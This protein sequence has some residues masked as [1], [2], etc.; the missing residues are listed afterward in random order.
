MRC[1][2]GLPIAI[3]LTAAVAQTAV[4]ADPSP[5]VF[6]SEYHV[7]NWQVEDGLPQNSVNAIAQT[8]DGFLWMGTLNGLV[9]FDGSRFDSI[10]LYD[11]PEFRS[12]PYVWSLEVSPDGVLWIGAQRGLFRLE[13]GRF[14]RLD[15]PGLPHGGHVGSLYHDRAG[16][17]WIG[18]NQGVLFCHTGGT[19]RR[20]DQRD[21]LPGEAITTI[22]KDSSGVLWL[23][24]TGG[25][26]RFDRVSVQSCERQAGAPSA[27]VYALVP[28]P[29]AGVWVAT[30][31]EGA[32]HLSDAGIDR[33][34][35]MSSPQKQI[36]TLY[37][38][39][40]GTLWIGLAY[41]GL[42]VMRAGERRRG[43]VLDPLLD[44]EH[45]HCIFEDRDGNLWIG[46]EG[47]GLFC[48]RLKPLRAV[49]VAD[50]LPSD[51]VSTVFESRAGSVWVGTEYGLA[52]MEAGGRIVVHRNGDRFED[53]YICALGESSGGDL[54]IGTSS[55]LWKL[56]ARGFHRVAPFA[57]VVWSICT[58]S[59]SD[60]WVGTSSGLY[61]L[62]DGTL[63][64]ESGDPVLASAEISQIQADAAG[65]VWVGTRVDGIF[66]IDGRSCTRFTEKNGL[67]DRAIAA[68]MVGSD[69]TTWAA[70][71]SGLASY[72]RGSWRSLRAPF[73]SAEFTAILEDGED[74]WL[75]S[76][77]GILKVSKRQ[78]EEQMNGRD[79]VIV[80]AVFGR[81][82]GM[83]SSECNGGRYPSAIAT[84]QGL[85]LFS[86]IKGLV[87]LDLRRLHGRPSPPTPYVVDAS[88]DG[89]RISTGLAFTAQAGAR[90][91]DFAYSCIDF[92][93]SESPQF[94]CMLE[95]F[96]EAW[97][98]AGSD[99]L[100][101]YTNLKPGRYRFRVRAC[102]RDGIWSHD[103][104]EV[105]FRLLP[106][107]RQTWY[108]IALCA[109]AGGTAVWLLYLVRLRQIK[110]RFG[111]VFAER[112][113]ISRELHDTLAQDLTSV[114]LKLAAIGKQPGGEP[115]AT[116]EILTLARGLI[117][118]GL[119]EVRRSVA[120]LRLLALEGHDLPHALLE[121]VRKGVAGTSVNARVD[122]IG[123]ARPLPYRTELNL[124]RV[125]QEAV[126]NAVKH[127]RGS[128]VVVEVEYRPASI[129]MRV[130]DH[131][132]GMA[133]S[134][135]PPRD[136]G[137]YGLVGM[138]ERVS[139]LGGTMEVRSREGEGTEIAIEAPAERR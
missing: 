75:G 105:E 16:A 131:G 118:D 99:R 70:T 7:Q 14:S 87:I 9:R 120:D 130:R 112:Q 72:R 126:A 2:P 134:E 77:K 68:L 114:S 125:A 67:A 1:M 49:T 89:H 124:F 85:L 122:V 76:A 19:V 93:S 109:G 102:S 94:V 55:G 113:R 52:Q 95:G 63:R 22:C 88:V 45:I 66:R 4:V 29:T 46:T 60:T 25:L 54:L 129:A 20:Y 41:N 86:T 123:A 104:A 8:P 132:E 139:L 15:L 56:A 21:G 38:S 24:T 13:K 32:F 101:Q 3:A 98:S 65:A 62:R 111:A 6:A 110:A 58:D 96:E 61:R 121:M 53:N 69:G 59:K 71:R 28:H 23:G 73:A 64:K 50:G 10:G 119:R 51:F 30:G 100:A 90:S 92:A 82:E 27:T 31:S 78:I 47:A 39:R 40:E 35:L 18:T 128:E 37:R 36:H 117:G 83:I 106:L 136:G 11:F 103:A 80:P 97:R 115:A 127:S 33:S 91:F 84:R 108:F 12:D 133:A 116:E 81:P 48:L 74:L 5:L 107:F 135:A 57:G 26:Y 17:L 79:E 44:R 34:A 42:E 43:L 137:G 138:R